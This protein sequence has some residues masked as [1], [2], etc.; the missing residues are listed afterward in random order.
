MSISVSSIIKVS[1]IKSNDM[2]TFPGKVI[3]IA[4]PFSLISPVS[5]LND[6]VVSLMLVEN[7][8]DLA[9]SEP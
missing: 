4:S 3:G 6:D 2:T 7:K 5:A 8:L 1:F 9:S